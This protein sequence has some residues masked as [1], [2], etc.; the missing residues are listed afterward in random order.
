MGI[1][2]KK[3][4]GKMVFYDGS[5]EHEPKWVCNNCG[6]ELVELDIK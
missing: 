4:K 2:C 1:N 6:L 3:C 5:L